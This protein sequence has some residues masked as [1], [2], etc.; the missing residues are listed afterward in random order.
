MKTR[1]I[2]FACVFAIFNSGCASTRPNGAAATPIEKTTFSG[3]VQ[4]VYYF[5]AV[6]PDCTSGGLP[7]LEVVR[8]ASHGSISFQNVEHY[9]EFPSTNQRYECNKQKS[10]SVAVVYTSEE[11]Y[12]GTDRFAV[13]SVF[14]SGSSQTKEFVVT[15]EPPH[16]TQP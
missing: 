10:P 2:H 8:A 5:Y 7:T 6:N 11:T 4:T 1:F 12:V 14:P 13:K 15:V 16:R 3:T 9:T